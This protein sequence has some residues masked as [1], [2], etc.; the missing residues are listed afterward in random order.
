MVATPT[1]LLSQNFYFT[2]KGYFYD[3]YRVHGF[4]NRYLYV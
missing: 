4:K 1:N 3:F 2:K